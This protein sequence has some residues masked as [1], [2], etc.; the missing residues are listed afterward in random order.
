MA[1]ASPTRSP[2]ASTSPSRLTKSCDP[3][4]NIYLDHSER[5]TASASSRTL[6]PAVVPSSARFLR[7]GCTC[8]ARNLLFFR[9]ER[10]EELLLRF[11]WWLFSR[12]SGLR[13]WYGFLRGRLPDRQILAHFFKP[14]RP[15]A[16]NRQQII[17]AFERAV[18]LAHL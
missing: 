9:T 8:G 5:N 7:S 18:R 10:Q 1:S 11:V 6:S 12:R 2:S 3:A 13:R 4:H 15:E 14:L 17:H 16:A